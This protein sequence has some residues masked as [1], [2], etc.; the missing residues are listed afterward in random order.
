M[1]PGHSEPLPTFFPRESRCLY[2]GRTGGVPGVLPDCCWPSF[3]YSEWLVVL[4]KPSVPVFV[5]LV[6][7]VFRGVWIIAY[8]RDLRWLI[9]AVVLW[10]VGSCV[11]SILLPGFGPY[12][13][14]GSEFGTRIATIA[15]MGL[16]VS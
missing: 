3:S 7:A 13:Q 8:F 6:L 9:G 11:T 4:G 5:W 1:D 10:V 16:T 12:P 2:A 15:C 14:P